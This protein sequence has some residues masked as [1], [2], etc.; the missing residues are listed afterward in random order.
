MRKSILVCLIG[1]FLIVSTVVPAA[2]QRTSLGLGNMAIKLDHISFTDDV[3]ENSDVD[4]G[5]YVGIEGFGEISPNL[6]LGVEV[7]YANIDGSINVWGIPVDTEVTF[8]PVELNFKYVL[9]AAPRLVIDFGA[10]VSFNYVEEKASALGVSADEDDLLFGG[11]F[12]MDLS[13]TVNEFFLG[14]NGKYQI[15]EEFKDWDYDYNNWRIGGQ[16]GL[17]F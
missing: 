6:Y 16:V 13:Y 10:G 9:E 11:Q 4:S 12:F 15:T 3:L 5:L 2:G 1:A 8:I 17:M 14:V 7:G